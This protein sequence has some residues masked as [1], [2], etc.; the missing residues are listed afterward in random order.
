MHTENEQR[1]YERI[2]T[3]VLKTG[4]AI[5]RIENTSSDGWPD[6]LVRT[7]VAEH[8]WLELKVAKGL[9][10]T[11]KVRATQ[12]SWAE[13]HHARGGIV[14][15]LAQDPSNPRKFWVIHPKVLR[16]RAKT[17]CLGSPYYDL[18]DIPSLMKRWT[19]DH[20]N[21]QQSRPALAKERPALDFTPKRVVVTRAAMSALRRSRI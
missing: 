16:E 10:K 14:R 19:G 11:I 21:I 2:K 18:D 3:R 1:F 13:D 6:V 12:I 7:D 5:D 8:I 9:Q 15:L 20:V 4:A 17:N